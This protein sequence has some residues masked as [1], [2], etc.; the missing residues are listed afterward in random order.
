MSN[1]PSVPPS[2]SRHPERH[3]RIGDAERSAASADLGEHYAQGR[4]T[5]EEHAE[6]L[7]LIWSARTRAELAPA[8]ADLPGRPGHPAA[9]QTSTP[10]Y[11]RSGSVWSGLARLPAPL[12]VLL[13]VLLA[14]GVA[15]SLPWL[16]VGLGVWFFF[17]R[18][19]CHSSHRSH[20]W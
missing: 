7:D 17:L 3:L 19:G 9:G 11:T 2:L 8:F 12:L 10:G 15:A 6:R 14:V 5:T 4:L 20:R 18:G 1:Y 13:A 16:L